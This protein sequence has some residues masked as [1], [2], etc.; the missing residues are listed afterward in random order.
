MHQSPSEADNS[1]RAGQGLPRFL[2]NLKDQYYV[3]NCPPFDPVRCQI[4]PAH[5]FTPYVTS[6]VSIF[7]HLCPGLIIMNLQE[8]GWGETD[9]DWIH[10]AQARDKW[11]ALVKSVMNLQV[12]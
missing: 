2:L 1:H 9:V 7:L 10:L 8:T 12:P 6:D 3:R 4:N 5:I 11:R